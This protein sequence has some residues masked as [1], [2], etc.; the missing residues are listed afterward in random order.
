MSNWQFEQSSRLRRKM[1]P[2]SMVGIAEGAVEPGDALISWRRGGNGVRYCHLISM[3][4][5][6]AMAAEAGLRVVTQFEG[7]GGMNL[8]SVLEV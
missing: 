5:V 6:E 7:D 1:V 2:W 8:Y 4:E 3:D